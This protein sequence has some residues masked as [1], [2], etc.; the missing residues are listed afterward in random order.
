[1]R[2]MTSGEIGNE[3]QARNTGSSQDAAF[4]T[5]GSNWPGVGGARCALPTYVDRPAAVS[6]ELPAGQA[7]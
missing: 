6:A 5:Q 2:V 1:M 7:A 3:G 4:S